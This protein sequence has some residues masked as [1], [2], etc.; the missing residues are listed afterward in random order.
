MAQEHWLHEASNA[1]LA[2]L[3][4][5]LV[6]LLSAEKLPGS[7]YLPIKTFSQ[8]L[9]HWAN[10]VRGATQRM[11]PR[12][13]ANPSG[14][15]FSEN[16]FR[17][18]ALVCVL[19]ERFGVHFNENLKGEP[20]SKK[21]LSESQV[22]LSD[23]RPNFLHGL[24]LG[25]DGTCGSMP[26]LYV[27]VGRRLGYPLRLAT[28]RRHCFA[29]WDDPVT[30]ERFNI[31]GTNRGLSCHPDAYYRRRAEPA[32]AELDAGDDMAS[33]SPREELAH[34]LQLRADCHIANGDAASGLAYRRL[35]C[36]LHPRNAWYRQ[37]CRSAQWLLHEIAHRRYRY[38]P[39]RRSS[40]TVGNAGF[41]CRVPD[42]AS[43][44]YY[45]EDLIH[46]VRRLRHPYSTL[47]L[48]RND[49]LT[50]GEPAREPLTAD[51]F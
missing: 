8:T 25:L 12:F 19:Q 45:Y 11:L 24:L 18:L 15:F 17:I 23:S 14:Y 20:G 9:D 6:N 28:I 42:G 44:V 3:G 40:L 1:K 7:E 51:W 16:Y 32:S 31:E 37:E 2:R 47:G 41:F 21:L 35:A 26:V 48:P 4:I 43:D 46:H 50:A 33:L 13:Y 36:E 22:F 5:D 27:A 30:G 39:L 10:Y 34:F 49:A 29:R 38:F